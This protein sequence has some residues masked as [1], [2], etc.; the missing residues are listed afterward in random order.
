MP[1]PCSSWHLISKLFYCVSAFCNFIDYR[2]T[3]YH[4][5]IMSCLAFQHHILK[6]AVPVFVNRCKILIALFYQDFSLKLPGF[7]ASALHNKAPP[8]VPDL[9]HQ[10]SVKKYHWNMITF[11][12]FNNDGSVRSVNQIN[13]CKITSFFNK[14]SIWSFWVN[15]LWSAFWIFKVMEIP[16]SFPF[17]WYMTEAG[18]WFLT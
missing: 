10:L 11:C 12:F 3:A 2:H 18:K 13:A 5:I 14:I 6:N 17:L 15:W 7:K 9:L 4:G 1:D 8:S 16:Q